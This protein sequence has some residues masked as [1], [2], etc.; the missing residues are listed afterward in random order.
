MKA[1][2]LT[3]SDGSSYQVAELPNDAAEGV[4]IRFSPRAVTWVKFTVTSSRPGTENL[5][6]AE[7]VVMRANAR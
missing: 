7:I 2:E 4:E 1:G 5:G 3:L 6:L